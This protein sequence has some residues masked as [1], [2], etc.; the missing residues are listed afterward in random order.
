MGR[1]EE[2]QVAELLCVC[3]FWKIGETQMK[4]M[5]DSNIF[6]K[7]LETDEGG[8]IAE[9]NIEILITSVQLEELA[10]TPDK[11]IEKRR[12]FIIKLCSLRPRLV[13]NS[14]LAGKCRAG[15]AVADTG[16]QYKA[17][18]NDI[19]SKEKK[20]KN[21][22]NDALIADAALREGCI[23]VTDDAACREAMNKNGGTAITW[24]DFKAQ[25]ISS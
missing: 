4:Y 7:L 8:F 6:D 1:A 13:P 11:K 21:N 14:A 18:K 2:K 24:K 17:I 20:G 3:A 22:T 19:D 10:N 5:F 15:L 16:I 9:Q 23:L 12:N 25:Y